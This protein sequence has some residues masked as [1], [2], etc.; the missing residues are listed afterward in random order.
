MRE[1]FPSGSGNP[2]RVVLDTNV[3]YSALHTPGS[4]LEALIEAGVRD[5]KYHLIASPF[6]L[7]ELDEKLREEFLWEEARALVVVKKIVRAAE[8]V[9][10]KTV[11]AVIADDPDDNHVLACALAG[12]ADLIVSGDR[13]LLSLKGLRGHPHRAPQGLSP[14]PG[15][16]VTG[17]PSSFD[18]IPRPPMMETARAR[19]RRLGGSPF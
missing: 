3:Y 11:T 1:A 4:R 13:H 12:H 6:I 17:D 19:P 15:E 16:R 8:R 5:R 7:H 2:F 18:R 10:P 14:H 9:N